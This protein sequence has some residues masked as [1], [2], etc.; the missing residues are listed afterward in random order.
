MLIVGVCGGSG[1]GKSTLVAA[2]Q[3]HL[4]AF[5]GVAILP[6]DAYY[7]SLPPSHD[8]AHRNFDDPRALDLALVRRHLDQAR[9]HPQRPLRL[10]RYDFA[11]HRRLSTPTL[12]AMDA[13]EI[14]LVEGV[15]LFA[16]ARLRRSLDV[17]VFVDCPVDLRFIRRLQRDVRERGR[18]PEG[19]IQ[20]YLA[21]VRPMDAIHVAPQRKWAHAIVKS[22]GS[23]DQLDRQAARLARQLL[24]RAQARQGRRPV[25]PVTV[26]PHAPE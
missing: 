20:Q 12:L 14:L 22:E 10:P 21:T 5:A 11:H 8:P 19:V 23:L 15:L 2:L 16:D 18:T 4:A 13:V 7:R 1:S 26:K 6:L 9:R 25:A 24:R 17:R 3:R